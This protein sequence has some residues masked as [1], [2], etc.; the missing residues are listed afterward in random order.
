MET[1]VDDQHGSVGDYFIDQVPGRAD[2]PEC[3]GEKSIA[4]Q[5][6]RVFVLCGVLCD[7]PQ[8]I[9]DA[10]IGIQR[11]SPGIGSALNRVRMRIDEAR[12]QQ[13]AIQIAQLRLGTN[14]RRRARRIP[15]IDN[16][17]SRYGDR[18]GPWPGRI[19]R[20][21]PG[22]GEDEIRCILLR[23]FVAAPAEDHGAEQRRNK[24]ATQAPI[25]PLSR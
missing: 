11:Q 4:E 1:F 10:A 12:Q 7:C 6:R 25:R 18:L 3:R 14:Q 2:R 22:V 13:P 5:D 20:V 24:S 19:D 15:D 17:I 21:D 16:F 8:P 23:R 9:V